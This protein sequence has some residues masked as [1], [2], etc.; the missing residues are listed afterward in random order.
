MIA[1]YFEK[2][3]RW[4]HDTI[5]SS[6]IR[7]LSDSMEGRKLKKALPP[8]ITYIVVAAVLIGQLLLGQ[9]PGSFA[10]FLLAS[11]LISS[12][13]LAALTIACCPSQAHRVPL[14]A[15]IGVAILAALQCVMGAC[16][17]CLP[18]QINRT[19]F[20]LLSAAV[21]LCLCMS[22]SKSFVKS[23]IQHLA[24][25]KSKVAA[26]VP[27]QQARPSSD[28]ESEDFEDAGGSS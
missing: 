1:G 25:A 24:A 17:M 23:G 5:R 28:S 15:C 6:A 26:S 10:A 7:E 11:P 12:A 21:I 18:F 3:Q 8:I 27:A 2:A 19:A 20:S 13:L 22:V 14:Y 9:W 16:A 4:V